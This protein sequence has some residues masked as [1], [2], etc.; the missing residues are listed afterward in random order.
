MQLRTSPSRIGSG[1]FTH[2][3]LSRPGGAGLLEV[4]SGIYVTG[5]S[6]AEHECDV[7][8]IY[9]DEGNACRAKGISPRS[10]GVLWA[11]EA[12]FYVA[13][14]VGLSKAREYFGFLRSIT[15]LLMVRVP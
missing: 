4:H 15:Q 14:N 10:R 1:N 11:M 3:V 6:G 5:G 9:R 13:A 2:L 7:A 8:V 12:K